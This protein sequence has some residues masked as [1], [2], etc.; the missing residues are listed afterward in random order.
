[1]RF[2][3]NTLLTTAATVVFASGVSAQLTD[4][5]PGRNFG[6]TAQF[7]T[8]RSENIDVGDA[9]NDGDLDVIVGNG[10][11]GGAQP[12]KIYIND[13][14]GAWTDQSGT[15]FAGVPN[16]TTRDI[17]FMDM[18]DDGDLDVYVSNRGTVAN[19]GETSRFYTNRGGLQGPNVGFYVEQTNTRWGSLTSVPGSDQILGGNQG[20]FRDYS[21]DCDF[22]DLDDDGD[23][24]LFHSSYGPSIN[25][26][27]DSRIFMNDGTGTFDEQWPWINGGGDIKTHTL[28][29]DIVDLDGDFDLDVVMSSRD[30][31][32]RVY[33]NNL[34]NPSSGSLFQDITG[35]ALIATG[36]TLSGTNNYEC[37]PVDADGDG[38]F[39]I[40]MKNYNGNRDRLLRNNGNLPPTFT[41]MNAW[42]VGDPN[43]D[44]NEV[45]FGDYDGDG[46]LDAFAANFSGTNWL[47]QGGLAQGLNPG[48][49]GIFHRTGGGGS[50]A[51]GWHELPTTNGQTT[52]DGEW[53]DI[54][55]DG[56]EDLVLANDGNGQNRQFRNALGVPD[57]HAPTFHQ[58][59]TVSSPTAGQ[60]VIVH[61]QVRDNSAYYLTAY[62][63]AELIYSV[64]GG[65]DQ[66][67]DMFSQ[68]GQ[69]FRAS[70]PAQNGSVDW[71]IEVTDMN[72]NT[73]VSSNFNYNQGT[74]SGWTDLGGGHPGVSGIP[75]LAGTGTLVTGQPFTL[76]LTNAATTASATV[77]ASF[78]DTPTP[79]KGGTLHTVPVAFSLAFVTDGSGQVLLGGP[80]PAGAGGLTFYLQYAITDAAASKGV[81]ISN[82]LR[83]DVP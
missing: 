75:N 10:G 53:V 27:R 41:Q 15:R 20:P 76:N 81:S 57:V 34:Y 46:D 7:G 8:Y 26:T 59:T 30:S 29:M 55:G 71:H 24:D 17:E 58:I 33:M 37:E 43:V 60:P 61:A 49:Q 13:G 9:D 47:Y 67:I 3:F 12:N 32:A 22:A 21:C 68:A 72:G 40:W 62:Y 42:I 18:D 56:D 48:T 63:D 35:S 80:W 73:G 25:G 1:M 51:A 44:E 64:N 74:G 28:D 69:Q 4:L 11:D 36:A 5:Q 2:S 38:D 65:G 31:Q 45:D 23:L 54:D 14:T 77:F 52:L 6:Q 16:D 83:A 66:T 70:I 19:G 50:L 39:D 78:L 82:Y 79:F